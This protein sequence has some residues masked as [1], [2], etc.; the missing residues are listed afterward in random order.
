MLRDIQ[1]EF[2][3]Q[4]LEAKI[5]KYWEEQKI[6]TK[7]KKAREK[8]EK[9]YILDGPPFATGIVHIG[10]A[11]NKVLK[12]VLI[13]YHMMNGKNVVAIP[14]FDM[15]GVPIELMLEQS[16]MLKGK[17]EIE[18]F[19][20]EKFIE[21]CRD[22]TLENKNKMIEEYKMLGIWFDWDRTYLTLSDAYIASVWWSIA[23]AYERGF[24]VEMERVV[25]VCPRCETA[26]SDNEVDY[27]EIK[28]RGVYVMVPLKGRTDEFILAWTPYPWIVTGA[29]AIAVNPET[30]YIKVKVKTGGEEHIL[31]TC[32]QNFEKVI[33][34][35]HY[36][37]TEI[38][39]TIKGESLKGIE[40]IPPL[41]I[42][43]PYHQEVKGEWVHKIVTSKRVQPVHTGAFFVSPGMGTVEFEIG[44][45]YNLP[46]FNPFEIDGTFTSKIINKYARFR[47]DDANSLIT[48]DLKDGEVL[49]AEVEEIVRAGHC[50]RCGSQLL[51]IP[52]RQWFIRTKGM[53]D[54]LLET[55][56]G[57]KWMPPWVGTGRMYDFLSHLKD[58]CISRQ[59]YWGIPMPIWK[60]S[61]GNTKVVSS[62]EELKTGRGFVEGQSLH[63]PSINNVV[64]TCDKCG[65]EMRRVEDT[66][67]VY[68]DSGVASWAS[69]GYPGKKEEFN[70]L[71]P[72]DIIVESIGQT[73]NWFFSQMVLSMIAFDKPPYQTVFA[74]GHVV[75]EK[76]KTV[77][78]VSPN[79]DTPRNLAGR[80][81]YD[82]L[83][84]Y[85]LSKEPWQ[86]LVYSE[87]RIKGFYRSLSILWNCAVFA[88]LYMRN[89]KVELRDLT[90]E[91]VRDHLSTEDR[92]MLSRL[93]N[94]K[95]QATSEMEN[96]AYHK[97]WKIAERFIKGEFSR[98]YIKAVR[99]RI[100][101]KGL[102]HEKMAAYYTLAE[103]L[104]GLAKILAPLAPHVA[105]EIYLTYDARHESVFFE[106]YPAANKVLI[107]ERI[108]KKMKIAMEI[109]KEI[110]RARANAGIPSRI[111]LRRVIVKSDKEET[112]ESA[113]DFEKLITQFV[114]ARKVEILPL[115]KDWDELI[116]EVV[117]NPSAIGL[118]Y[119]QWA[120]KIGHLLKLQSAKKIKEGIE[121]GEYMLGIEGQLVRILPNMVSFKSKLPEKVV[122]APITNGTIYVD[123]NFTEEDIVDSNI[124]SLVR[125]IMEMRKE[126]RLNVDDIVDLYIATDEQLQNILLSYVDNI[127]NK[128][129]AR[130]I[131]FVSGEV[132]GEY[133]V[134][135]NLRETSLVLGIT[136]LYFKS[137]LEKFMGIP[138]MT[139]ERGKALFNAGYVSLEKLKTATVD[140][141]QKIPGIGK[142]FAKKIVSYFAAPPA[143]QKPE[144]L[145]EKK[146]EAVEEERLP[147]VEKTIP[148]GIAP[149]PAQEKQAQAQ[150]AIPEPSE[151]ERENFVRLMM[152]KYTIPGLGPS[153]ARA[154]YDAGYRTVE[155]LASAKI[156]DLARM[157]AIGENLARRIL[158]Y[159]SE[160]GVTP[161]QAPAEPAASVPKTEQVVES[162]VEKVAEKSGGGEMEEKPVEFRQGYSYIIKCERADRAYKYL[163]DYMSK[164]KPKVICVTRDYPEKIKQKYELEDVPII[165]L[166]NV[167]KENAVRPKDLEKLSLILEQFLSK[168]RDSVIFLDGIEYLI[169]NNNFI[170]VL[171]LIQSLKDQIAIN[172][173][174]LLIPINPATMEASQFNLI[175]REVDDVI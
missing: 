155:M 60:C 35:R 32:K 149:S 96:F 131:E 10:H 124:R 64:F 40:Y 6:Y 161:V 134:E 34:Y 62:I 171:R 148:G 108:E 69:L 54:R 28:V 36:D 46:V 160:F 116:L 175:E 5:F 127:K 165:W 25:P 114:N 137:T 27:R 90:Y 49:Y 112:F 115:G 132:P 173:A 78:N 61:C 106:H 129:N 86:D 13:R 21:K 100:R 169:T 4:A 77:T 53:R 73:K 71:W 101:A 163:K 104:S 94:L 92:W 156:E 91:N 7:I 136:P 31:I 3:L 2:N 30:E 43:V 79:V 82:A 89:D 158:S 122:S 145:P 65:K 125:I 19:G 58:W 37:S 103:V 51:H 15:H 174:M 1:K 41:L 67:D 8:S 135:W 111:P 9:L 70:A 154:L 44:Q 20:L 98:I 88:N 80:Y 113:K 143:A 102:S 168:N 66:V 45:E 16:L 50:W 48:R 47:Y 85:L 52:T 18:R 123:L 110:N 172:N 159:L 84:L 107:D 119:R 121:R 93:E 150:T 63:I 142:T 99:E 157:P 75:D 39:D 29:L 138:G 170:T 57:I 152:T 147:A 12:D 166:S 14:G 87:E 81:G 24:L 146:V 139:P 153:K 117:P 120:S 144:T 95:L 128:V 11:R 162:G 42:E 55:S 83:R 68:I 126:M 141:L 23:R 74:H 133:V 56:E 26:I 130:N 22:F 109:V 164:A 33:G 76:R 59:R 105:E 151:K 38:L 140:D 167:G 97:L 72:A 118:V 17:K